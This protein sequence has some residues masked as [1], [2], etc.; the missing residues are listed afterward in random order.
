MKRTP[1][2]R[3]TPLRRTRWRAR[4]VTWDAMNK[5]E[6]SRPAKRR[7]KYK[8]RP[9][10]TT[11]M[12]WVKRQ[13]CIV[14]VLLYDTYP[15]RGMVALCTG[16]VQADHAGRRGVN[17]KADDTTCIPLCKK[18]HGHRSDFTGVF[19]GWTQEHM[20]HFLASAIKHTQQQHENYLAIRSYR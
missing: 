6:V 1:L 12:L 10:D 19:R 7:S 5:Q 4:V 11:Y 2:R 15:P 3:K 9:R 16:E 13:P 14:S 18:H 8:R 17:Q 20:R